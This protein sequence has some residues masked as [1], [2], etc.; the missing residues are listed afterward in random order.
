MELTKVTGSVIKDSVSLSG[1][2]SVGGTLTYQDVTNVDALGIGTFRTGIKVLAGQVDVG[3]NIKLGNAGVITATS[4][5]GVMS[6]TTG[7]FSGQVN[8][9]SNIKLGT[10]GVVTAT[11]FSGSGASLT[12]LNASAIASGTVPTARLGSGTASSST[13]LRGDSTFAAVTST[14]INSNADNRVITGSGTANTLNGEANLTFD[15]STLGLTGSQTISGDL[16]IAQNLVHTGDTD[17]KLEFGTDTVKLFTAGV[18]KFRIYDDGVVSIGQSTKSSTVGA[19]N[20]DIQGNATSCILEMGN[21]FPGFSGGV[22]P[23][24]RIT[25]TLSGHEVKFESIWGGDNALH[26]HIGFTGGRTHFYRATNSDEIAR[27]DA[28]KFFI[29]QTTGSSRLCVSDTNP[30]IAE[31][32]HSDGG[33]ND[34][35]RISLGALAN[36]PPSNRGVNLIAENNGAGHDFVVACSP[37]HSGGPT[38]KVRISSGGD[39]MVG[40]TSSSSSTASSG[41][42]LNAD[43]AIISRRNG[44]MQYYKSI[45]TGGYYANIFLSANTT[46]GSIFFNSGGTQF[47]TSSDYRRK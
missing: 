38:E 27:F 15:G 34:Q 46:V 47:N 5:S 16:S 45:A 18:Q 41:I 10:A 8:V 6:G 3:S 1:N 17:T 20:L 4:F 40:T 11:T 7:S 25:A 32:H 39:F 21:P 26:P 13:F 43:G 35:A 30:V 42:S 37:S 44:V 29:G 19:G 14:T 24:F 28:D 33:T 9:G 31:L 23:E 22:V 12:N 2:V 36:N